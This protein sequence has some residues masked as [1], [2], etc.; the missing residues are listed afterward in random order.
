MHLRKFGLLSFLDL[1]QAVLKRL[2]IWQIFLWTE[3]RWI[4]RVN[5]KIRL[6]TGLEKCFTDLIFDRDPRFSEDFNHNNF[7]FSLNRWC[8]KKW[9][10]ISY[11]YKLDMIFGCFHRLFYY[12]YLELV[13]SYFQPRQKCLLNFM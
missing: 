3:I 12:F 13:T 11:I 10:V 4:T 7:G 5:S 9:S 8:I 1:A 6:E 2:V